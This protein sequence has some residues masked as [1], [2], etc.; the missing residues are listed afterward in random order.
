MEAGS[1]EELP[2]KLNVRF[3]STDQNLT[4][5]AEPEGFED[6]NAAVDPVDLSLESL[7]LPPPY[8][9]FSDRQTTAPPDDWCSQLNFSGALNPSHS[10]S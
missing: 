10:V 9:A 3:T 2:A 6:F 1:S 7:F 8:R 5:P 4:E